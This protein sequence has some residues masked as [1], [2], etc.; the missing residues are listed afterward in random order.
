MSNKK[1]TVTFIKKCAVGLMAA[2]MIVGTCA[3][4]AEAKTAKPSLPGKSLVI[5]P[6][7]KVTWELRGIKG[8]KIK[9]VTV[10]TKNKSLI[11]V[12]EWGK[13]GIKVK[14]L[15]KTGK[16]QITVKVI[17]KGKTYTIKA[18]VIINKY[19][20]MLQEVLEANLSEN[21]DM[22]DADGLR[23]VTGIS[24]E[25]NVKA[26]KK[27]YL[28]A[29]AYFDATT[30]TNIVKWFKSPDL[31]DEDVATET[32]V[33]RG[34]FT[35]NA[36][37]TTTYSDCY[38]YEY[39]EMTDGKYGHMVKYL[40]GPNDIGDAGNSAFQDQKDYR[41]IYIEGEGAGLNPYVSPMFVPDYAGDVKYQKTDDSVVFTYNVVKYETIKVTAYK[42]DAG[43]LANRIKTMEITASDGSRT[44]TY[45]YKYAASPS[46][47]VDD[48]EA[49]PMDE[50]LV[51]KESDEVKKLIDGTD[52]KVVVNYSMNSTLPEQEKKKGSY[53]LTTGKDVTFAV[54]F[55][56]YSN[57]EFYLLQE[58]GTE[59]LMAG[60]SP[61]ENE[62]YLN[63]E[64]T[65]ANPVT[66]VW[67]EVAAG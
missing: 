38:A 43:I 39:R 41:H 32:Y 30:G 53:E 45:T 18:P 8:L 56:P 67:K 12:S 20:E 9:K 28:S 17:T 14:G 25:K 1:A 66:V 2:T 57:G 29:Q 52:K 50:K 34:M 31:L 65:P 21:W 51:L 63:P 37:G 19:R 40:L 46:G 55:A 48:P 62:K 42:P 4:P 6:R 15:G 61:Y 16:T 7:Q 60:I 26:G 54:W 36:D 27:K 24:I 3:V 47:K 23:K 44:D 58:D 35:E 33:S 13:Q 10:T 59:V 5:S 11:K 22:P 49:V 64:T